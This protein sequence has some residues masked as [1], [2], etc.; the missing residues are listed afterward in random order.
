[1]TTDGNTLFTVLTELDRGTEYQIKIA[2]LNVNG[3]GPFTDWIT[4]STFERDLDETRVPLKPLMVQGL[5][6]FQNFRKMLN[7]Q[8][9]LFNLPQLKHLQT[10][11]QS[12]GCLRRTRT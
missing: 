2:A 11:S 4:A 3:T 6:F 8:T 1:M 5:F 7:F 12:P 9:L 10:Q